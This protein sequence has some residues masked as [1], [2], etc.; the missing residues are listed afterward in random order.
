MIKID[1]FML[2]NIFNNPNLSQTFDA[3]AKKPAP[4]LGLA[5]IS[6]QPSD[7]SVSSSIK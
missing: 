3:R 6:I 4:C 7:Y 1:D 5:Y 2:Y